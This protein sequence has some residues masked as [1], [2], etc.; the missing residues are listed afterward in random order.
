MSNGWP[1]RA[2]YLQI[3]GNAGEF[4]TK[5]GGERS[6]SLGAPSVC[7]HAA[8]HTTPNAISDDNEVVLLVAF[9]EDRKV[10]ALPVEERV[11]LRTNDAHFHDAFLSYVASLECPYTRDGGAV[12][13]ETFDK[14][15]LWLLAH[16][17]GVEYED[18]GA[19]CRRP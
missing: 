1:S 14:C 8:T 13:R 9:L 6:S 17:I 16:A 10:R 5:F 18:S 15:V 2:V 19:C 7:C 12:D 3:Y 4:T 11:P